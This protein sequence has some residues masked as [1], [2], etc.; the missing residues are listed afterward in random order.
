MNHH[1]EPDS[2]ARRSAHSNSST[3]STAH[4]AQETSPK[5]SSHIVQPPPPPSPHPNAERFSEARRA[6]AEKR[7]M[8][9]NKTIPSLQKPLVESFNICGNECASDTT[10]G[11]TSDDISDTEEEIYFAVAARAEQAMPCTEHDIIL[12]RCTELRRCMRE[13]PCLPCLQPGKEL[14]ADELALGVRLPQ[15]SCPFAVCCF[16]SDDRVL[17]LHHVAGGVG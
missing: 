17:F 11:S 16:S 2:D 7:L 6:R 1:V 14:S 12:Q 15:Y 5:A 10:S 3:A 4:A 9:Q 8:K 13:R